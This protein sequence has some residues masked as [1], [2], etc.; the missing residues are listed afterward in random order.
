MNDDDDETT[1]MNPS[2]GL[3]FSIHS[4]HSIQYSIKIVSGNDVP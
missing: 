2:L 1:A 3:T 4:M